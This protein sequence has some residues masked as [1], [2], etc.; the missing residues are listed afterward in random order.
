M[1]PFKGKHL[2]HNLPTLC[3]AIVV[4]QFDKRQTKVPF[5]GESLNQFITNSRYGNPHY[6]KL[7][8]YFSPAISILQL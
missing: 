8:K 2:I 4:F 5:D 3:D 1:A 6:H 7:Y